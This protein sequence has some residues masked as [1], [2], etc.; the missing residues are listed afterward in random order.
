MGLLSCI[1]TVWTSGHAW[2][3]PM[4]L[5]RQ[6]ATVLVY[7]TSVHTVLVA[8]HLSTVFGVRWLMCPREALPHVF[9][10]C[11]VRS[12]AG[13]RAES[14][15]SRGRPPSSR[16][17]PP[18]C[19]VRH[20][21]HFS[22]HAPCSTDCDRSAGLPLPPSLA[23]PPSAVSTTVVDGR[24][25]PPSLTHRRGCGRHLYR[26][27]PLH[28][29][30]FSYAPQP[31]WAPSP[32]SQRTM[33]APP[34]A[35]R[36]RGGTPPPPPPGSPPAPSRA[37]RRAT[38]AA[39]AAA[40]AAEASAAAA[41]STAAAAASSSAVPPPPHPG[42][43]ADA[44]ARAE[45][46]DA[47][48]R[49]LR[50]ERAALWRVVRA[51]TAAGGDAADVWVDGAG[52][53]GGGGG[54]G[55]DVGGGGGGDRDGDGGGGGGAGRPPLAN[56]VAAAGAGG[57]PSPPA[58]APPPPADA[59]SELADA[60]R[61]VAAEREACRAAAADVRAYALA[62]ADA[63]AA[64]ARKAA[65]DEFEAGKRRLRERMLAV[66]G[67]QRRRV[68]AIRC[69]GTFSLMLLSCEGRGGRCVEMSCR[70]GGQRR[71]WDCIN[72]VGGGQERRLWENGLLGA[73]AV[74]SGGCCVAAVCVENVH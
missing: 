25:I 41:T 73:R 31:A 37:G 28:T 71:R 26:A 10:T 60:I 66:N 47:D 46:L 21:R 64:A 15:S 49:A 51:A 65:A 55:W 58:P 50:A 63:A 11:G 52:A 2:L 39:A 42:R 8:G 61:R 38:A 33:G 5:A 24:V 54:G 13:W 16:P 17:C 35:A 19:S 22:A 53:P 43:D 6:R 29:R 62:A 30:P 70:C 7:R 32:L 9:A 72:A 14:P 56:G 23:A 20:T 36:D 40:A 59:V 57:P 18:R 69:S 44:A 1:L 27:P 4:C 3:S 34:P 45:Q 68:D 67:E 74:M 12:S 48:A